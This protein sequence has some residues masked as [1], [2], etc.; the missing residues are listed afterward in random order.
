MLKLVSIAFSG[1]DFMGYSTQ[2]HSP[3]VERKYLR[4]GKII[5]FVILDSFFSSSPIYLAF[6]IHFDLMNSFDF[7]FNFI[8]VC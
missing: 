2:S 4:D 5:G 6:G 7:I 1:L 8:D 3:M